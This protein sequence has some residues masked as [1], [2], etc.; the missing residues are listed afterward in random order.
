MNSIT[1]FS[2]VGPVIQIAPGQ[3]SIDDPAAVSIL[4]RAG[5]PFVKVHQIEM[6]LRVFSPISPT[7]SIWNYL[8]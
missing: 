1:D 8:S 4:Y 3:Y 2:F 7:I 5:K 6:A